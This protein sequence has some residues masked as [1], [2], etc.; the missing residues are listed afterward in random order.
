M[1]S[2]QVVMRP[3]DIVVLLKIISYGNEPWLQTPMATDLVIS[4]SELSKSMARSKNAGLLDDSGRKVR[5][6]A[7]M[8][9]LEG[10]IA[11]VFPQHPGAI[12]RGVATSHSAPPLNGLIQSDDNYVWPSAK[13]K[14][15]GQAIM[16]LYKSVPDA[17]L[18]DPKLH[19]MLALVDAIRVGSAREK[20]LAVTELRKRILE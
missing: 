11:F 8:D 18:N 17:V 15:R 1:K 3:H 10:G 5:R 14:L 19:E 6:L 2:E 9:F 12:V 13:G 20:K 16:P 4:Q 7:L